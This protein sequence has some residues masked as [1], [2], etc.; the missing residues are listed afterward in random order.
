MTIRVFEAQVKVGYKHYDVPSIHRVTV[1]G[2]DFG[3]AVYNAIAIVSKQKNIV[4][5]VK[6]VTV[7]E[8]DH[9]ISLGNIYTE[10]YQKCDK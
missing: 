7:K 10:N 8:I 4:D 2:E 3:D 9:S 5:S 6:E 1:T